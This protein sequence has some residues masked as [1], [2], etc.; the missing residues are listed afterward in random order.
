MVAAADV[1]R[2]HHFRGQVLQCAAALRQKL[3]RGHAGVLGIVIKKENTLAN[4]RGTGKDIPTAGCVF[5]AF[6]Q[7][8]CMR[9]TA[10]GN[11]DNIG[12]GVY[13]SL[14]FR[15]AVKPCLHA[16]SLALIEEPI[17]NAKDFSSALQFGGEV[18]LAAMQAR[19]FQNGDFVTARCAHASR[20]EARRTRANDNHVLGTLTGFCDDV[21]QSAFTS[22]CRIV[23]AQRFPFAIDPVDAV[24]HANAGT[25]LVLFAT[26]D[27]GDDMR[28]CDMGPGHADQI[29]QPLLNGV[30]G[31]C[32]I[33]DASGMHDRQVK[34]LFHFC[35]KLK[36]G[37]LGGAHVRDQGGKANAGR[38]VTAVNVEKIDHAGFGQQFT[39]LK[40][41]VELKTAIESFIKHHSDAHDKVI[42][43]LSANFLQHFN[44]KANPVLKRAAVFIGPAVDGRCPET[45]QQVPIGIDFNAIEIAVTTTCRCCAIG[46]NGAFNIPVLHRLG[47]G[48]VGGFPDSRGRDHGQPVAAVV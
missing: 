14:Y 41:L 23:C 13:D 37:R 43:H 34:M 33:I 9:K 44:G 45:V 32:D 48:A 24:A 46:L 7:V 21:R 17:G 8:T 15:V 39:D 29:Q 3:G 27:L 30:A 12:R 19:G 18:D 28:I 20:F 38:A 1:R 31:C 40:T 36:M 35:G 26:R 25:N 47:E 5:F 6:F 42:A 22:G 4:R 16:E 11:Q 2:D 10:C